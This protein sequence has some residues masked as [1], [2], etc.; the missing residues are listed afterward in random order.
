MK[1][2]K[3]RTI[4][5]NYDLWEDYAESAKEMCEENGIEPTENNIWEEIYFQDSLAWDD[6]KGRMEEFFDDGSTWLLVGTIETWRG[7]LDGGFLFTSFKEMWNKATKNCEYFHIFDKNG[8]F[9]IECSHHD[10]TN[11]YEIKRLT[12]KG[13]EYFDNWNY[14]TDS[15]TER[16]VHNKLM[17][18]YST[19]PHFANK[20]YGCPKVEYEK[21]IA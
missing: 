1:N 14:G 16:Y 6:E 13:V 12:E 19:L 3:C 5:N 2:P 7:N 20:Y 11:F 21:A 8:H 18:K 17:E 9:Y 10:G 15:R 4:Y